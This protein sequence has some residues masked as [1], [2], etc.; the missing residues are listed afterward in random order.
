MAVI[1]TAAFVRSSLGFG[2]AV[3]AMPLL[4][5]VI[6][7]KTAAP[8]VAFMGPAISILILAGSWKRGEW[9]AASKLIISSLLGIPL[10]IVLLTRLPEE[11]LRLALGVVIMLY[12][13]FGLL[14]PSLR[15]RRERPGVTFLVG[16][17]A[18][19]LGGAYNTNGPPVVIYGMLR[20]WPPDRFRA[21]LQSYFLPTGLAVLAGHGTAG[22]WTSDVLRLFA[23]SLPGL[24]L[25]VWAGGK[26]NKTLT[27]D[28]FRRAVHV[29]L[30]VMGGLL[31][32]R[33]LTS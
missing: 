26:V 12:G 13:G 18:G 33:S 2:D 4:A 28:V 10:G 6:G 14:S 29:S 24:V 7:I 30:V 11:P 31:I 8:L 22:L 17:G 5:L 1:L 20:D 15:L 21:T 25:G 19:V 23:F 27:H 9:K 32:V 16:F 3:L